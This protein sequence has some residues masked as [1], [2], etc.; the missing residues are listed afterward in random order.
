MPRLTHEEILGWLRENNSHALEQLFA[1][2]DETRHA[3]VG[4]AVH[5]RGLI[6]ISS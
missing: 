3:H 4:D 2:A 6:E 5:L 1:Q